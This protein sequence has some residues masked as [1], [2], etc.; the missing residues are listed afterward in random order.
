MD[1]LD[2]KKN[3]CDNQVAVVVAYLFSTLRKHKTIVLHPLHGDLRAT[4]MLRSVLTDMHVN[5]VNSL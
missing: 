2:P 4:R 5:A 1:A 3:K